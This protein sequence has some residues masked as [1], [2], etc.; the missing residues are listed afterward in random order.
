M[1]QTR[2]VIFDEK[3]VFNDD[4]EAA[5]LELKKT[6]TAQNMSLD[7]LTEL[8]QQLNETETRKQTESV[9]KLIPLADMMPR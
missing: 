9:M 7:Q 1:I 5:R 8:L 6:Q 3:I 4:I 2:N